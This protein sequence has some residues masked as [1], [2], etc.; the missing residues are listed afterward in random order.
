M[1]KQSFC[2][3]KQLDLVDFMSNRLLSQCLF[4]PTLNFSDILVYQSIE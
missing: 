2:M 1:H 3:H 4:L